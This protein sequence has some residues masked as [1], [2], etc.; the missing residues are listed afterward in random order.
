MSCVDAVETAQLQELLLHDICSSQCFSTGSP[1]VDASRRVKNQASQC[2]ITRPPSTSPIIE[3]RVHMPSGSSR[4]GSL[5]TQ[6]QNSQ[7]AP[8]D[9][10]PRPRRGRMWILFRIT[11]LVPKMFAERGTMK[12][13]IVPLRNLHALN[14]LC[15]IRRRG[16]ARH[17]NALTLWHQA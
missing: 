9:R 8:S 14:K 11:V 10:P 1:S 12:S 13:R 6:A 5:A 15:L 17:L 7:S 4:G 3:T 16:K 2:E